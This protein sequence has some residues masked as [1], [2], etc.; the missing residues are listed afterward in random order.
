MEI[1]KKLVGIVATCFEEK[2]IRK[3]E[4]MSDKLEN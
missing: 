3:L 4:K 1:L 2:L